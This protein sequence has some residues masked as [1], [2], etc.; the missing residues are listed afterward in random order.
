D[1]KWR[2]ER[3]PDPPED[4]SYDYYNG[5]HPDLQVEGYLAGDE[6]VELNN[7]TAD[8]NVLFKLSGL[9]L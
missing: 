7:L 2:K 3:S 1:E 4:F 5:A 6:D 8:G 9:R